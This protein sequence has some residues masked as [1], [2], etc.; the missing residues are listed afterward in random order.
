MKPKNQRLL[1]I[2]F[3]MVCMSAAL[4]LILSNFSDNLVFFYS[5]T[6]LIEKKVEADQNIRIGG[7]VKEGSVVKQAE[8]MKTSFEITDLENEIKVEY[9]GVLPNL[10]KEKMGMVAEGSINKSGVFIATR[11]L[12]KHDEKYMPPEVTESLKKSGKW[13]PEK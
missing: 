13:N 9:I 8:E 2:L 4:F 6:E 10:F 5:P 11:L 1:I 7:L 12:A 3:S